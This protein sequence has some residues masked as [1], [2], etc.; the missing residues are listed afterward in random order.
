MD[1]SSGVPRKRSEVWFAP[2][3][4]HSFKVVLSF[5]NILDDGAKG[6]NGC[7]CFCEGGPSGDRMQVCAAIR[8]SCR[9]CCHVI[10][11][12][13]DRRWVRLPDC[14]SDVVLRRGKTWRCTIVWRCLS[15]RWYV[16]SLTSPFSSLSVVLLFAIC[17]RQWMLVPPIWSPL[18]IDVTA[19]FCTAAPRR[20]EDSR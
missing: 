11:V 13:D 7:H 10:C 15:S 1:Q 19:S 17:A 6:R 12:I 20:S 5:G 4:V 18:S 8:E 14:G 3:A 16:S 2:P 9:W